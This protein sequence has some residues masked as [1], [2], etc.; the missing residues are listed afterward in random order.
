[1]NRKCIIEGNTIN[2]D[3]YR[4]E[5]FS[6]PKRDIVQLKNPKTGRYVKVDRDAGMIIGYKKTEGPYKNIPIAGKGS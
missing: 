5:V 1:M 2:V 3:S 6:M 4:S